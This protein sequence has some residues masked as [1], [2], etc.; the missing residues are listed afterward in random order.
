MIR[1]VVFA[2]A[3]VVGFAGAA[4]A[5]DLSGSYIG[6]AIAADSFKAAYGNDFDGLGAHGVGF[7]VFAGHDFAVATKSF[8]GVEANL[9]LSTAKSTVDEGAYSMELKYTWSWG[10]G[11]RA[12]FAVND[13]S[14]VYARAGY[15][16]TRLKIEEAGAGWAD[17][18]RL[19]V[20]GET[21]IAANTKLRLE[22]NYVNYEAGVTNNQAVLGVAFGF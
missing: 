8:V 6:G 3:A 14:T 16:R 20:G 9:D 17:G 2:T 10:V 5:A 18:L 19:G 13:S 7:S 12:G 4:Q 21:A 1:N 11:A 15:Q 22:Y